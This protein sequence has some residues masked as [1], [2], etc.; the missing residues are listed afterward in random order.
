MI[1]TTVKLD[2]ATVKDLMKL[3]K[4]KRE[5]YCDV[6]RRLIDERKKSK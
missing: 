3:K 2:R 1:N 5:T 4:Y 6:V